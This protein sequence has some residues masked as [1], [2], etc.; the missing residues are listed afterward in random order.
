LP[1]RS[2][3][4]SQGR[5]LNL[6]V[7]GGARGNPGPAA[8]AAVLTDQA[9]KVVHQGGYFLGRATNNVA[10]YQG[11][12][13]GLEAA[14]RMGANQ[15]S[16]YSDSELLVRQMQGKYRVKAPHLQP[17]HQQASLLCREFESCKIVHVRRE[18]NVLADRLVNQA[19]DAGRDVEDPVES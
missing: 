6:H 7:D 1:D 13:R 16:V 5:S 3:Y 11:L 18:Q 10:E 2:D 17:L 9:G 14:L 15:L 8:A 12:I 19:L 4:V